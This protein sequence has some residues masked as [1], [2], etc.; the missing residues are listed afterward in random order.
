MLDVEGGSSLAY[1][2]MVDAVTGKIWHRQNQAQSDNNVYPFQGEITATDCGPKHAFEVT[3]ATEAPRRRRRHGQLR[4]RHRG[5]ALR[6]ERPAAR[7]GRPRHQPR[8]RVVH[9]GLDPG[10]LVLAPG[11]P[12]PEPDRAVH[13][14]GQLRRLGHEQR[15]GPAG[16]GRRELRPALALLHRQPDPGLVGH[17]DARQLGDR[18]LGLRHRLHHPSGPFRNVA[19]PG[20]VG[21]HVHGR[22]DAHHGREQRQ[23]PRGVAQP[24]T[25]PAAPRRRRSPRPASTPRSSPTRG[26]TPSCDPTQLH[27]GGNDIDQVVTNLFVAHNR[28]HDF[29][30]YLGF[31]EENYNLQLDNLGRGGADGTT[32]RSATPRPAR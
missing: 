30:Y 22:A 3:G 24:A 21:R 5:E 31:T 6:P 9:G 17:E 13:S 26:T 18:L 23:H 32:P 1:T 29:S 2:S 11:L 4:G 19:G 12:L 15:P 10:R 7:L 27:P 20:P 8:D 16:A 25:A 14:P 28:M